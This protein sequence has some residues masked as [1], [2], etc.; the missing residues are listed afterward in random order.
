MYVYK[1]FKFFDIDEEF[2]KLKLIK[3]FKIDNN[4][5]TETLKKIIE[6]ES[7]LKNL[8]EILNCT[9][10]KKYFENVRRF[11]DIDYGMEILEEQ[12]MNDIDDDFLKEGFHK[13][14]D[15]LEKDKKFL[16]NLIIYKYLPQYK[17]AF[18]D[19]NMRIVINPIYFKFSGEMDENIRNNIFKA[20]LFII[21][22]HEIVHLVKFMNKE[23][24]QFN[25]IPKT[26]K[27][28]E[29]GKVFINYLFQ[30]PIIF[31]IT[32]KQASI[33]NKPENWNN[34]EELNKI[35][36]EQKRWYEEHKDEYNENKRPSSKE[37]DSISFYLSLIDENDVDKNI[38]NEI[39]DD[40]Y[41]ID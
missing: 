17:R 4:D 37:K 9:S 39:I 3:D 12:D 5:Y 8:K 36:E 30:L 24:N 2:D 22:L 25:D 40:W 32:D 20:Y 1:D 33:I 29:G 21:I 31:Y 18:V 10:V 23:S 26:P 13:L 7:F 16:S 41:D 28:K 34:L 15:Y 27:N 14:R 6:E 11:S 19:P 35:F 38:N